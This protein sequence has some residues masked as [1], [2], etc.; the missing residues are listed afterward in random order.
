MA[1]LFV[2]GGGIEE[3]EG[4]RGLAGGGRRRGF[5]ARRKKER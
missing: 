2:I 3:I 5:G 1:D 4:V